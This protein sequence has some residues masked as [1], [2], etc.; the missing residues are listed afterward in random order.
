MILQVNVAIE[1]AF[2]GI[3]FNVAVVA[4]ALLLQEVALQM[5]AKG[6]DGYLADVRLD[7][8]EFR[9]SHPLRLA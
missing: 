4:A 7:D 6:I 3:T 9:S 8:R 1:V 5:E 2:A